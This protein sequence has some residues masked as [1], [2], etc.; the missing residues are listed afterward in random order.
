[1]KKTTKGYRLW[2]IIFPIGLYY[3]IS[4]IAYYALE[5]VIGT[6]EETYMLRQ[7][8]CSTI[9]IPFMFTYYREDREAERMMSGQQKSEAKKMDWG[10]KQVKDILL[11]IV[12][13]AA[14]G[15]AVNNILAMT[16]LIEASSGFQVANDSFFAGQIGY[17]LLG[18]CL[19]IPIAEELLFRGLI[20]KRLKNFLYL[21]VE[22]GTDEKTAVVFPAIV[23]S[24]I[25]FGIVHA[26]MVQFVYAAVL[27]LLLAFLMEKTNYLYICVIGH[28]AANAMA[29]L[30][31]NTGL[32]DFAYEPTAGGIAFTILMAV[33]AGVCIAYMGKEYLKGR[34]EESILK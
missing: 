27:G 10:P 20:Y 25:I 1:M 26:N 34:E 9:T 19:L 31:Q 32:L 11:A 22:E 24:A 12:S 28:I 14:L 30:R 4:S 7:L 2:K 6:A 8:I 18:S 17:E 5:M 16:P 29:V 15:I 33:I 21:S 23:M 13:M 3:A